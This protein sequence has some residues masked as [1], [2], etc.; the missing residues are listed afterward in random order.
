MKLRMTISKK[1]F[2]LFAAFTL[3][4]VVLAAT[5]FTGLNGLRRTGREMRL[6]QDFKLQIT[7]L[8]SFQIGKKEE[9]KSPDRARFETEFSRAG[10]LLE[11]MQGREKDASPLSKKQISRVREHLTYYR[12]AFEELFE[13][14][15]QDLILQGKQEE[16]IE[17]FYGR[18]NGLP[19][20]QGFALYKIIHSLPVVFENV[21]RQPDG[22]NIGALKTA[23]RDVAGITTDPEIMKIYD[24]LVA[25]IEALYLNV[26]GIRDREDFLSDTARQFF[27][28]ASKSVADLA[29]EN[30]KKQEKLRRSIIGICLAAIV[31]TLIFWWEVSRYFQAFLKRQ[32]SAIEAIEKADYDYDLGPDI[33]HDELGD[34][35]RFMKGLAETMKNNMEKLKNSEKEVRIAKEEWERTFDAIGDIVTIQDTDMRIT[36]ANK[37]T[38]EIFGLQ[39]EVAIGKK[40]HE[41][42]RGINDC[43]LGCPVAEALAGF[44]SY[45]AE[46][47]H[48]ALGKTFLVSASPVVNASGELQRIV[49]FAKD[50]TEFKKLEMQFLQAQKMEAIGRLSSGVAHDFNNILSSILGYSELALLRKADDPGWRDDVEVIRRSGEKAAALIRQLLAFSRRKQLDIRS[51]NISETV[52]SLYKML[53]RMIGEDVVLDLQPADEVSI[54]KAD[55]GQIEQVIMNLAVNARDAMPS[56]GR[57]TI[58]TGNVMVDKQYARSQVDMA[59]GPYVMLAVSDNGHGMDR[60]VREHIFEP[61]F[62]TKQS[63]K[64]TGLGLATVYSIVKQHKGF[65]DVYSEPDKGT[66]FKLYFPAT[67]E[68]AVQLEHEKDGESPRYGNET[69]LVVDDESIIRQ[70]VVDSLEPFGYTLLGAACGE[71]ALRVADSYPGHIDLLLTDIIMPGMDGS[72]LAAKLLKKRPDIK[73]LFMSGYLDVKADSSGLVDSEKNFLSKPVMPSTLMRKLRETLR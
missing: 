17:T 53:L 61:F 24:S 73:L 5:V 21:S 11:Q 4:T 66:T 67:G 59:P 52:I 35:A 6:V 13:K 62:T 69:I 1:I 56:G 20:E 44:T 38:F 71:E 32:K 41:L 68:T 49:H 57:M 48:D 7:E 14:Y 8:S 33:P 15:K 10:E 65:I 37:A 3:L 43:C 34:L 26:L 18:V 63:G 39:P 19:V 72:S 58:R 29:R 23:R 70:I 47:V 25:N 9:L 40:C 27:D 31:L 28:F 54:I 51:V 12:R 30:G 45:T 16:L 46:I 55:P 22:V 2:L 42:F 60:E 36:R 50:I 64:G